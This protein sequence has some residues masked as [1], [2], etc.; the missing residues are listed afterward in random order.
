MVTFLP[1]TAPVLI[2]SANSAVVKSTGV[3]PLFV[4][5][6]GVTVQIIASAVPVKSTSILDHLG[7]AAGAAFTDHS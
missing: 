1:V 6:F 7:Y 4:P 2:N 5:S 3:A